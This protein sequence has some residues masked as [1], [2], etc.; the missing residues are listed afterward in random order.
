[1]D[2]NSKHITHLIENSIRDTIN[3]KNGEQVGSNQDEEIYFKRIIFSGERNLAV[4]EIGHEQQ[5]NLPE[6]FFANNTTRQAL[7]A[8]SNCSKVDIMDLGKN[9]YIYFWVTPN[10]QFE[11]ANLAYA[12]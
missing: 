11:T 7:L 12:I 4:V 3:E 8:H 6:S 2:K 5:R 10:E 9:T 1:M